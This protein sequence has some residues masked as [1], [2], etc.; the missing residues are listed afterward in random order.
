MVFSS[1]VSLNTMP[2]ETWRGCHVLLEEGTH[3]RGQP[4]GLTHSPQ[5]WKVISISN[6]YALPEYRHL[7]IGVLCIFRL[8][9]KCRGAMNFWYI[10]I[11]KMFYLLTRCECITL[12]LCLF[13]RQARICNKFLTLVSSLLN[14]ITFFVSLL[15]SSSPGQRSRMCYIP[16]IGVEQNTG[17]W[18]G[19]YK[20]IKDIKF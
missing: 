2:Q 6:Q 19:I 12:N 5:L 8:S 20:D 9:C 10:S 11:L 14:L 7:S 1:K 17:E 15:L 18:G 3:E 4:E 13:I 16:Q